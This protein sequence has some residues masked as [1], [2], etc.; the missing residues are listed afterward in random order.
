MSSRVGN[1]IRRSGVSFVSDKLPLALAGG[2]V[3]REHQALAKFLQ[4]NYPYGFS[5]NLAKANCVF[6]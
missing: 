2:Y 4:K 6:V 5:P 1:V 3:S